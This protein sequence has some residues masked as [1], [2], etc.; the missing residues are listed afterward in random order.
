MRVVPIIVKIWVPFSIA[1]L[2]ASAAVQLPLYNEQTAGMN[3]QIGAYASHPAS[4]PVLAVRLLLLPH[5]AFNP[6]PRLVL[7]HRPGGMEG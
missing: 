2:P 6:Q 3:S 1:T 7:I 5:K 4:E